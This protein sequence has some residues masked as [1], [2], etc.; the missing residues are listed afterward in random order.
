MNTA[1]TNTLP[2]PGQRIE[3][4]EMLDDFAV[5]AGSRGTV[6]KV[7]TLLGTHHVEVAWDS[8]SGLSLLSDVD[9]WKVLSRE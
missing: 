9:Q 6:L 3:C 1:H 2:K 4:I 7:G 5:P 8:G